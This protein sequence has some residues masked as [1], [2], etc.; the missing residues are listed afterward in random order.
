V[1]VFP[2]HEVEIA[3]TETGGN[4][5]HQHLATVRRVDVD[6]SHFQHGRDGGQDGSAHDDFLIDG[7]QYRPIVTSAD[8]GCAIVAEIC[9]VLPMP[10]LA[11][12]PTIGETHLLA[13]AEDARMDA[14]RFDTLTRAAGSRRGI[15]AGALGIGALFGLTNAAIARKRR[16]KKPCSH[17][18]IKVTCR[19]RCGTFRNPNSCSRKKRCTCKSGKTCLP[20][21][22]CGLSCATVD[23]PAG[24]GCSC[25]TSEPKVCLAAFTTCVDVPTTCETTADC[26]T[27]FACEVTAC[28]EEGGTEKRCLPLCGH[29][30]LPM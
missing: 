30:P 6:F 9:V 15:L 12:N 4:G 1:A 13:P 8:F 20:N 19:E 24:S 3:V 16:H 11:S 18:R 28:G 26:P 7:R 14:H 29:P 2:L 21:T 23:C 5:A 22:S 27:F 25:S 10:G 17:K